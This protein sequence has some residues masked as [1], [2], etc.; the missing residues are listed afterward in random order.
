MLQTQI[1]PFDGGQIINAQRFLSEDS[2]QELI[3]LS[4]AIGYEAATVNT[5][6]GHHLMPQW[7]NNARVIL[8]DHERA[9][10]LW[11]KIKS[12]IPLSLDHRP[13]V[14]VNERLRLVLMSACASIAM[15]RVN[16]LIGIPTVFSNAIMESAA[17]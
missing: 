14:G 16:N 8:D 7:R 12:W 6:G 17:N 1:I 13:A 9:V 4:E 2:C 11:E 5:P 3:E 10:W 15:R